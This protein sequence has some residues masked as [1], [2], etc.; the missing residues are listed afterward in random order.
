MFAFC[1]FFNR[2][3]LLLQAKSSFICHPCSVPI[4]KNKGKAADAIEELNKLEK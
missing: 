1:L 4:V 3:T 2:L